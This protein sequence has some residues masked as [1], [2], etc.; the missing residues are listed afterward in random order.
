MQMLGG[1]NDSRGG[2]SVDDGSYGGDN[3]GGNAGGYGGRVAAPAARPAP[4]SAAPAAFGPD[5]DDDIP[6]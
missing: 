1:R 3:Y 4:S 5:L 6:F 2:T